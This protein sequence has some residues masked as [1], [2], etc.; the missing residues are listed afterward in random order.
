[1]QYRKL[2]SLMNQDSLQAAKFVELM[3]GQVPYLPQGSRGLSFLSTGY[4]KKP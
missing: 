4:F 2:T 1:M 3:I